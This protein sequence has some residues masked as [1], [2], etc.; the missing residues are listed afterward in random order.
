MAA[1]NFTAQRGLSLLGDEKGAWMADTTEETLVG[2]EL[3]ANGVFAADT[4]WTKGDGWA[5]AAGVASCDGTQVAQSFLEQTITIPFAGDDDVW[6]SVQNR[7]AGSIVV[8]YATGTATISSDGTAESISADGTVRRNFVFSSGGTFTIR[9]AASLN[10]VGDIDNA[11]ARLAVPDLSANENG[12]G[13]YGSIIKTAVN[14]GADLV[15]YSGY[16]ASDYLEQP[17]NADFDPGTGIVRVGF[18]LN[19]SANSAIE[20]IYERD[21]ATTAQRVTI[22]VDA[23]GNLVFTC[24]D[25]TTVRSVTSTIVVDDDVWRYIEC[26]YSAGTLSL[27][28]DGALNNIAT[29][30]ALLTLTNT[31]A[32]I[33]WGLSVAD[34]NPLTNGAL[35]LCVASIT[36]TTAAQIK[37]IYNK[38]KHLFKKHSYYTQEGVQYDLDVGLRAADPTYNV[39]KNET[40]TLGGKRRSIV[41][42][43]DTGWSLALQ[44]LHRTDNTRVR[45]S[46]F[47]ELLYSTRGSEE[48]TVDLYGTVAIPDEPMTVTRVGKTTR[49]PREAGSRDWFRAAINVLEVE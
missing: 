1:I 22:E 49:V 34:A 24:D 4:D 25:D 15:G 2:S 31:A 23:A 46:E 33:R 16:G 11:A 5:I 17:Y 21:S 10:F 35:A 32:V 18:W 9:Y 7:T 3:V 6:A 43:E 30:T 29:G 8:S 26:V 47:V 28:I 27:Y 48:F 39:D 13:V 36:A 19:Q 38:E 42:R 12:L 37:T 41:H 14:T 20:T 44:L 40:V 45:L